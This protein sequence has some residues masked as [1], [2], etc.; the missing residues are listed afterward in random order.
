MSRLIYA[1]FMRLKKDKCFWIGVIIMA[2]MGMFLPLYSFFQMQKYPDYTVSL[3]SSF[4]NYIMLVLFISSAFCSL[5]IGT[6]Y[7]D[8]TIRNKLMVGHKRAHIYL[9]NLIVCVAAEYVMCFAFIVVNLCVG[10]PLLGFFSGGA[11]RMLAYSGAAA[12]MLVAVTSIYTMVAMLNQNKAVTSVICIFGIFIMFFCGAYMNSRINEPAIY[13]A[14]SYV[15]YSTDE[16]IEVE[17]IP[18]PN[19]ISGTKRAVYEFLNDF[20]PGNQAFMLWEGIAVHLGMMA[21][22][23]VMIAVIVTG[24]GIFIFR[25]EDIK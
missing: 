10:I 22:Y 5:Y 24:A 7:S 25:N 15:D 20:L 17:A 18:N 11:A 4:T 23:S 8:G 12:V 16:L 14:H 13:E 21:L 3:E 19:Y 6:E 1:D 2:F 9:S